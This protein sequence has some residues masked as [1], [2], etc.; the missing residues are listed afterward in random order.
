ML[1]VEIFS[2]A[3]PFDVACH[4]GE[5]SRQGIDSSVYGNVFPEI[6]RYTFLDGGS[7]FIEIL[8]NGMRR[9]LS[10]ILTNRPSILHDAEKLEFLTGR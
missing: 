3:N 5:I 2:N 10:D 4:W 8:I 6:V 9:A 7:V 1:V